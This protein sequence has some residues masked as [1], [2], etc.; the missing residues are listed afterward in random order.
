MSEKDKILIIQTG[1][2]GDLILTSKFVHEIEKHF[3]NKKIVFL[4]DT[5][6]VNVVKN[7]SKG[8]FD[9]IPYNRKQ[10]YKPINFLKF[11]IKFPYRNQISSAFVL[12]F[13]KK[14]RVFLA[15]I[16]GVKKVYDLN[17]LCSKKEYIEKCK[18]EKKHIK[19]GYKDGD[20]IYF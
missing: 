9:V 4:C 19:I 10:D 5:P 13:N 11:I 18:S 8:I 17:K 15:R 20:M 7:L 14:V 16:L 6:Y 1:Y 2:F 12:H 3:P